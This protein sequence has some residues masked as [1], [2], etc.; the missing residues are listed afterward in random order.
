MHTGQREQEANE[1]SK[2]G[3]E[4]IQSAREALD[5]ASGKAEPARVVLAETVD[6]KAIRERLGLSQTAFA[7][8]FGLS[9]GTV[10]DWEQKRRVPDRPAQVLLRVIERDAEAVR[11]V[12]SEDAGQRLAG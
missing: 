2:F 3:A 7:R 5:I 12:V 4:L 1:M 6:V 8:D 9:P 11:R 10:R